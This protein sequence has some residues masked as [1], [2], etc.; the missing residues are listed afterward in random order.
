MRSDR[1]VYLEGVPN[2]GSAFLAIETRLRRRK[3]SASQKPRV[4]GKPR[5]I[6]DPARD[7]VALIVSSLSQFCSMQRNRNNHGIRNRMHQTGKS[8]GNVPSKLNANKR[9]VL[10]LQPMNQCLHSAFLFEVKRR[11]QSVNEALTAQALL[12]FQIE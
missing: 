2:I 5:Q 9:H 10:I 7:V 4:Y 3:P 1:S 6:T 11:H 12:H 8:N